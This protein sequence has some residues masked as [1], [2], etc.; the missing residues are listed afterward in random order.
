MKTLSYYVFDN[1]RGIL[2]N[3]HGEFFDIDGISLKL[4]IE[5]KEADVFRGLI[6]EL[7]VG[8]ILGVVS[9][10]QE[11]FEERKK[12]FSKLNIKDDVIV[13]SYSNYIP[14]HGILSG[15]GY[16]LMFV[17]DL[18]EI[19]SKPKSYR[20]VNLSSRNYIINKDFIDDRFMLDDNGTHIPFYLPNGS[21]THYSLP[22]LVEK[23]Y[24]YD[25]QSQIEY[26]EYMGVANKKNSETPLFTVRTDTTIFYYVGRNAKYRDVNSVRTMKN[27][28]NS[29]EYIVIPFDKKEAVS[30]QITDKEDYRYL[31]EIYYKY[32]M[33]Q[34]EHEFKDKIVEFFKTLEFNFFDNIS[35]I[36]RKKINNFI[37][38]K[39]YLFF[40]TMYKL[41]NKEFNH[42]KESESF[43]ISIH[44]NILAQERL[45]KA[46]KYFI[47]PLVGDTNS[48]YMYG[49]DKNM[50]MV[51]R[52]SD[53]EL[54]YHFLNN[55][56]KIYEV[57]INFIAK[58]TNELIKN[59]TVIVDLVKIYDFLIDLFPCGSRTYFAMWLYLSKPDRKLCNKLSEKEKSR[60]S[61][62]LSVK[63]K[64]F[65]TNLKQD[66]RKM[67]D[68]I[69]GKFLE[70]EYNFNI[71]F[72]VNTERIYIED[73][74][75]VDGVE[76]GVCHILPNSKTYMDDFLKPHIYEKPK[77][78][79]FFLKK[80][81]LIG[82]FFKDSDLFPDRAYIRVVKKEFL[83]GYDFNV[84]KIFDVVKKEF[85]NGY[86]FNVEKIFDV[87]KKDGLT[88]TSI[89][90]NILQTIEI[91]FKIG[92]SFDLRKI[93]YNDKQYWVLWL[94]K[95]NDETKVF[96]TE[97]Y[98]IG[99]IKERRDYKVFDVTP[100][101]G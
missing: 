71:E 42:F 98:V 57:V 68:F 22:L 96:D 51:R 28:D 77:Y 90:N 20:V 75:F 66:V 8:K 65:I 43:N 78:E 11:T 4:G 93:N 32:I 21:Y 63:P 38:S 52:F 88:E 91:D 85:L 94:Y 74:R 59:K 99:N 73:N 70:D 83:N 18:P 5:F 87:V 76:K 2:F 84:E 34:H 79:N 56:I 29:K 30:S 69:W 41:V 95:F 89:S 23:I 9:E 1:L 17:S 26:R 47:N 13:I 81:L 49:R 80:G 72:V 15:F 48:N 40:G 3:Y 67:F 14:E 60:I 16:S 82:E 35:E 7:K 50:V 31:A 44:D 33:L 46:V 6:S 58:M 64:D 39:L 53:K 97:I 62:F 37:F 86:D 12:F 24:D 101:A 45:K 61:S 100:T 55:D 54:K 36:Q 25:Y 27:H 10:Q 19:F 92:E